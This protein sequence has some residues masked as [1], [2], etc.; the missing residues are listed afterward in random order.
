MKNDEVINYIDDSIILGKDFD[1]H[2]KN[3]D[4]ALEAFEKAGLKLNIEKCKLVNQE[5]EFLGQVITPEGIKPIQK[6]IDTILDIPNPK[7]QKQL[8]SLLAKFNYYAKFIKNPAAI[9]APLCELAKGHF[10]HPKN[11]RITLT[12]EALKAIDTMKRKLTNAPILGFPNFYSGKP[13]MVT[14]DASFVGFAYIISQEQDGKG[15]I[16][17]YGSKKLSE[18]KSRYQ[19]NKLELLSVVTYLE[20]NK[21]FLYRK[22]FILRVDNKSLCYMKNLSPLEDW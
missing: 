5:A 4:K 13:F 21:I 16:L 2:L 18:A 9:L 8:R 20:K 12:T 7:N 3:L 15:R 17:E 19:I 10:E 6:H 1:G 14:T 11:V 22:E